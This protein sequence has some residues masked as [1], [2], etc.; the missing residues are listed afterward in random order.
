MARCSDTDRSLHRITRGR[1]RATLLASLAAVVGALA[2]GCGISAEST[3]RDLD[4]VAPIA[5]NSNEQQADG[6]GQIYLVVPD[7][8]GAPVRLVTVTRNVDTN[9]EL[10]PTSVL[11]VLFDGP[12]S[13]ERS[14]SITT[15]LPPGLTLQ[16][17]GVRSGGV[18][19]IDLSDAFNDL[20]GDRLK[21]ALAQIVYTVTE[22][23][24]V[25]GIRIAVDGEQMS[26]PD[27]N[28]LLKDGPLTVFDY[29]GLLRSTQPDFP[30]V[31]SN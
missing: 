6:E 5:N 13:A 2:A 26:W 10:D 27:I 28:G 7:A 24:Q 3:P 29:P 17:W 9:G 11:T 30:A 31:P 12:N 20:S 19:S 25:N 16:D 23:E 22:N 15:V 8:S 14:D 1:R 21:F 4:Q 18:I